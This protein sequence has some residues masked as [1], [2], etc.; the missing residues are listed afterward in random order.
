MK[1]MQFVNLE[2]YYKPISS[3]KLCKIFLRLC[4]KIFKD[5]S[6]PQCLATPPKKQ[7]QKKQ[8]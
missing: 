2:I 5:Q 8:K 7:K 3:K 6:L 4:K 1:K